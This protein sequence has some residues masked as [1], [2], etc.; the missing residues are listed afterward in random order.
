MAEIKQK[1]TGR[2]GMVAHLGTNDLREV[3]ARIAA[4]NAHARQVFEAMAYGIA[5]QIGAMAAALA[6]RVDAVILTGGLAADKAF[7]Q[8]IEERIRWI[9]RVMVIPGE[10]EMLS[11]ALGAFR[12]L[13]G[14]E[15][16]KSY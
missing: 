5:K 16:L 10:Q 4:G 7:V 13:S 12:V 2:G 15:K 3:S 8:A 14:L 11:L 1:L 6:G 9:G